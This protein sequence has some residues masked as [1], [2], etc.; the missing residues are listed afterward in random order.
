MEEPIFVIIL[1]LIIYF[2]P[3]FIGHNKKQSNGI[4]LLN[5]LLGW[6]ILGWIG[7]LIWASIAENTNTEKR[8]IYRCKKCNYKTTYNQKL[9]LF[10]CPNCKTETHYK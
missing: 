3:A 10:V 9:N 1:F 4:I 6:T 5:L 7:A 2:I 8:Y